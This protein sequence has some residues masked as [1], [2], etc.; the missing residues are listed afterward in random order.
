MACKTT[1]VTVSPV[2]PE[3]PAPAPTRN[4][5]FGSSDDQSKDFLSYLRS[6]ADDGDEGT[7]NGSVRERTAK[8]D[9]N[10]KQT[11]KKTDTDGTAN[12]IATPVLPQAG[13]SAPPL[14]IT[15]LL[16]LSTPQK[17]DVAETGKTTDSDGKAVLSL[18][19]ISAD[20][21]STAGNDATIPAPLTPGFKADKVQSPQK[22]RSDSAKTRVDPP[23]PLNAVAPQ[24]ILDVASSN[25]NS[26][27]DAVN[28]ISAAAGNEASGS[29]VEV[30]T[31]GAPPSE[32]ASV[33]ESDNLAFALRLSEGPPDSKVQQQSQQAQTVEPTSG[34]IQA[35]N[36]NLATIVQA[37]AGSQLKEQSQQ[38]D[39]NA[40]TAFYEAPQT[41]SQNTADAPQS[42]SEQPVSTKAAE[43]QAKQEA[44]TSE[45]VRNVHMQVIGDNNSRVDVRLIDR[46]GELHVSVKSGDINLAQNLQDHMPELTSRLEQQRFQTEVWV[47]K[48]ADNSKTEMSG[49][50]DFS[51][52]GNNSSNSGN[53]SDQQGKRQQYQ[54][55]WVDVL[56]NSTQG[57]G[58]IN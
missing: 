3:T 44:A 49:A 21:Q 36:A 29:N 10:E 34:V 14:S 56:E 35:G 50:R 45:P 26:K 15:A 6:S 9:K 42:P 24:Q 16:G 5:P 7:P 58:K 47:P 20:Q 23:V 48:L 32:A 51:S 41:H 8:T 28:S 18:S 11:G 4:R 57:T 30:L 22:D 25:E 46:G 55:D 52:S 12:T 40:G 37:T 53:R 38:H 17:T 31:A 19:D 1:S 2:I 43:L 13:Q 33:P 27:P 54:P 39:S